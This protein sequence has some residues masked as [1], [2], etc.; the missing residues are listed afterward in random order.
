M[1][2]IVCRRDA[3][4]RLLLSVANRRCAL[5]AGFDRRA[6][7]DLRLV[8]ACATA[9]QLGDDVRA[10]SDRGANFALLLPI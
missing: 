4:A 7:E 5:P 1:I 2:R 9:H 10:E 3:D 8:I 6:S